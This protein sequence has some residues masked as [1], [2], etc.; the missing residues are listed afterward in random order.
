MLLDLSDGATK[1]V[2]LVLCI[3]VSDVT[4]NPLSR[5]GHPQPSSPPLYKK[6][7]LWVDCS[8]VT[9]RVTSSSC[10]LACIC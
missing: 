2:T 10:E 8:R 9:A 5:W 4:Y 6:L 3:S 1:C 7:C